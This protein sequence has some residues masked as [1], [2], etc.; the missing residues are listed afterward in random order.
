[1]ENYV[2]DIAKIDKKDRFDAIVSVLEK[3]NI[4]YRL[5]RVCDGRAFGNIIV[6]YN[7]GPTEKIVLGAHYD[8]VK[9]TPGANDN[10]AA[11]SILLNL[12]TELKD[13]KKHIEFVFFDLEELQGIGSYVY[14]KYNKVPI[15]EFINL[16]MCGSG[17]NIVISTDYL[18]DSEFDDIYNEFNVMKVQLLPC[19][20]ATIFINN[21]IPTL[22]IINSASCD[23]GWFRDLH[24]GLF[25][26]EFP[27]FFKTM[28]TPN[29]TV[30]KLNLK[31][32]EQIFM[33]TKTIIEKIK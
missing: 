20:D 17:E 21:K 12:I 9:G 10:A 19:S 28:H 1:M 24:K 15:K 18:D 2:N 5:Q 29:D 14:L 27:E 25:Y 3:N 6:E 31:Q 8:N 7:Q 22:Y 33:F 11:C 16:D 4:E 32:M 26:N 23:L 13:A 30:D